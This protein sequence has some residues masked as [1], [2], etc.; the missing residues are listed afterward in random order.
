[1]DPIHSRAHKHNRAIKNSQA[2]LQSRRQGL[3]GCF[4]LE[5]ERGAVSWQGC[6]SRCLKDVSSECVM[7]GDILLWNYLSR[8]GEMVGWY[9]GAE[10]E[11]KVLLAGCV[12][13]GAG[14]TLDAVW[15]HMAWLSVSECVGCR[16]PWTRVMS[17]FIS[18]LK[19]W[20][21]RSHL[22]CES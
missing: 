12:L 13:S 18:C 21:E 11:T 20:A 9:R 15:L 2:S 22:V 4:I 7:D 16:C 14:M 10:A 8:R 6:T 19:Q 17:L 3:S 5:R 1:M